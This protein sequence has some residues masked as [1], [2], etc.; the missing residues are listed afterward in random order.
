MPE[1][2]NNKRIALLSDVHGNLPALEAVLDDAV[3]RG[4]EELWY[5][6]DFLGYAPFPNEVVQKLREARAVSIIG[7]YDLKVLAFGQKQENWKAHEDAREIRRL[8]VEL[9][10]PLAQR[11]KPTW[12]RCRSRPGFK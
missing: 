12:S 9:R 6:G 2:K 3:G 8:S 5:G 10:T 1:K 11:R 4:A 7:N